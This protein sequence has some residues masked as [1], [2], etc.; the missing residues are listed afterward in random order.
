MN[1]RRYTRYRMH[2][3]VCVPVPGARNVVVPGLVSR[4]SR[5]GMEV[6]AGVNVLPG[7]VMEVE[8]R[9]AGR[10]IR[11]AGLVRNRSG[12]CFGVEFCG[13]RVE[14]DRVQ[15]WPGLAVG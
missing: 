4:L 12:F 7:E 10:T 13:L 15:A 14:V 9:T 6:Y 11:I 1:T 2:T 8:F 3:P 5:A